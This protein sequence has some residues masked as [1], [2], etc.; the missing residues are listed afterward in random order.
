MLRGLCLASVMML[1]TRLFA[2]DVDREAGECS[3]IVSLSKGKS[4]ERRER[5]QDGLGMVCG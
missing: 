5:R 1:Q 4:F 2:C 3:T